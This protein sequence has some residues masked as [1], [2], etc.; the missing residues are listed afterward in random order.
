MDPGSPLAHNSLGMALRL[1][2]RD[3]EAEAAYREAIRLNPDQAEAHYNLGILLM[4]VGDY[5]GALSELRTSNELG[6]KRPNWSTSTSKWIRKLEA[7]D[8]RL[9]AIL[10]GEDKPADNAERLALAKMCYYSRRFATA[11]RFWAEA[12]EDDPTLAD[13]RDEQQAFY[14]ACAAA[15]AAA[16][17]GE[18]DPKPDEAAKA[19]L[20]GQ[21]L[22]WL[23]AELAVWSKSHASADPAARGAI[24]R[25]LRSW[26]LNPRLSGI[27]DPEALAE[28][29]DEEQQ[30][31]R[32][33]WADVDTLLKQALAP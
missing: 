6:S 29:P 27:R 2:G 31:W 13:D 4:E 17:Q 7:L 16:G 10:K 11:A 8:D 15:R 9:P 32:A 1:Q 24:A 3:K 12:L 20:R 25:D 22:T 5:R 26:Q 33:L 30:A 23:R 14:A 21:A 28:L 18:D 19:A